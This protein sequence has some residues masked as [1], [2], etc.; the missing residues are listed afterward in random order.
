MG[1]KYQRKHYVIT[2]WQDDDL[3]Q[4]GKIEDIMIVQDTV[5]FRIICTETLGI[6]R[7]FH[8]FIINIVNREVTVVAYSEL[9]DHQVF[10]AHLVN[11][12]H[13]RIY[14]TFRSHIERL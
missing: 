1:T 2:A 5:F 14:I 8:S 10:N 6:D 4:F 11:D 12:N 7:H 3:P 9:V 13:Q